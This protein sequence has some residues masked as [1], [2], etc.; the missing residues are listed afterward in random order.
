MGPFTRRALENSERLRFH[1]EMTHDDIGLTGPIEYDIRDYTAWLMSLRW[2]GA[3]WLSKSDAPY[4][5]W[6]GADHG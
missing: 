6:L 5:F 4:C 1:R 3:K 2:S